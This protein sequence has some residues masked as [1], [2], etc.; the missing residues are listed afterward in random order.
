MKKNNI[1]LLSLLV[2]SFSLCITSC[3]QQE[4]NEI[5]AEEYKSQIK[6]VAKVGCTTTPGET[7]ERIE[8]PRD[9]GFDPEKLESVEQLARQLDT[10][11]LL[12]SKCGK[13]LVEFGT[14][15]TKRP[16]NSMRKP[17]MGAVYEKYVADG[18]IDLNKTLG[19]YG[20]N[21][22]DG[23]SQLELSATLNDVIRHRS[24]VYHT[25]LFETPK[26]KATK[27]PR[28]SKVPGEF[29]YYNNFDANVLY[30]IFVNETGERF[31]SSFK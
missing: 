10:D 17:F 22:V 23:L 8:N 4:E 18:T 21:D 28:D 11:A 30:T 5:F 2:T 19:Q 25:S 9:F 27:P 24:G 7:L 13:I 31:F 20:I 16:I 12:V 26:M 6:D 15:A 3:T 14:P 1:L 29:F